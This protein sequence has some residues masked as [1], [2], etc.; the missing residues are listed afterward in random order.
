MRIKHRDTLGHLG[1]PGHL[2]QKNGPATVPL[3]RAPRRWDS[4]TVKSPKGR[5]EEDGIQ[6]AIF[7]HIRLRGVPGLIAI[8]VPNGGYRRKTEAKILQGLGVTAGTPDILAWHGGRSFAIE[9]KPIGGRPSDAQ[10]DMLDR[11][12][13]AGV[14]VAV[15]YGLDRALATLESWKL[16]RGRC[17]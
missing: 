15:C 1:Q 2:G 8:H 16:L 5:R 9:L 10:L 13:G 3:S 12:S 4:G 11:L 6:R 17:V 14:I 7:Q